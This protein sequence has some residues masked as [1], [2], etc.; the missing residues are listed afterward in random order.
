[1]S[2]QAAATYTVDWGDGSPVETG[3]P[4]KS[5]HLHPWK[6]NGTYVVWITKESTG[7]KTR[8][9]FTVSTVFGT[10]TGTTPVL[11]ATVTSATTWEVTMTSTEPGHRYDIDWGDGTTEKNVLLTP[12]GMKHNYPRPT[13]ATATYTITATRLDTQMTATTTITVDAKIPDL[14]VTVTGDKSKRIYTLQTDNPGATYTVDWGDGS[15]VE[16]VTMPAAGISH[17]FTTDGAKNI[18]VT[19]TATSKT[20]T[21]DLNV[22]GVAPV[23][24]AFVTNQST[25]EVTVDTD[26]P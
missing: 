8:L 25:F 16:T 18:K 14:T 20:G 11:A 13:G 5:I 7:K 17:T 6:A 1:M 3:V 21:T 19:N 4:A 26:Q 23:L 22:A 24:H 9:V 10:T 12:T 15:P 2:P